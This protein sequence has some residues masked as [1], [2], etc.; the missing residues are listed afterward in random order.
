MVK[1]DTAGV[2]YTSLEL[3]LHPVGEI[4]VLSGAV[5]PPRV[6]SLS[7][8]APRPRPQSPAPPGASKAPGAKEGSLELG[9]VSAY[10]ERAMF[11]QV[12]SKG[13]EK[14]APGEALYWAQRARGGPQEARE[15]CEGLQTLEKSGSWRVCTPQPG[16]SRPHPGRIRLL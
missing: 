12:Y 14:W 10:E 4:Q 3:S 13:L 1:A 9:L 11:G 15:S 7:G 8:R 16:Q 2:P 5:P 6:G